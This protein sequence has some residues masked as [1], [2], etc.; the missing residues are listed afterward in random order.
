MPVTERNQ[1]TTTASVPATLA[2]LPGCHAPG[3]QHPVIVEVNPHAMTN[4]VWCV[5]R[6]Y[7]TLPPRSG[8]N[9]R[10]LISHASRLLQPDPGW[11]QRR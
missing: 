2:R 4:L 10:M 1:A 6:G 5:Q 11:R 3:N 7:S 8:V 9:K